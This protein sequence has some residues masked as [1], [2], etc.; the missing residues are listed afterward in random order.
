MVPMEAISPGQYTVS[1][2]QGMFTFQTLNTMIFFLEIL[3]VI[4]DD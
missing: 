1:N 4:T 2:F 3:R